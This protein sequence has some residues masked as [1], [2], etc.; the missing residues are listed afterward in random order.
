MDAN[1]YVKDQ[2]NHIGC[3]HKRHF[4]DTFI[5]KIEEHST[6]SE[7]QKFLLEQ[8]HKI[9]NCQLDK[10]REYAEE[11]DYAVGCVSTSMTNMPLE[12]LKED[13]TEDTEKK[14]KKRKLSEKAK[15]DD[16]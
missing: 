10:A 1:M 11:H 5:L 3:G 9:Y 12:D 14:S 16:E 15:D 13:D 6:A 4:T 8:C 2:R 7:V